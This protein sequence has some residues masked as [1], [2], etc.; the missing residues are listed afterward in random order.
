MPSSLSDWRRRPGSGRAVWRSLRSEPFNL[1]GSSSAVMFDYRTKVRAP[2][3]CYRALNLC[4][5]PRRCRADGCCA[6]AMLQQK[7]QDK[8]FMATLAKGLAVLGSFDKQ[9]P[10][11][12]LSQ[13]AQATGLSRATARRI[14][15]TLAELGYVVQNGRH[16]TLS[17]RIDRK[18]TRLNSSH[19]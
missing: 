12:T 11:M 8:E 19:E 4:Q 1:H 13:A 17:S 5:S 16:F 9:R 14:L 15:R 7:P 10:V 6:G 18:S 2:Y 3:D